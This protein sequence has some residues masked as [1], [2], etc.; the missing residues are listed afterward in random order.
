MIMSII[1]EQLYSLIALLSSIWAMSRLPSREGKSLKTNDLH[2]P[3]K[4]YRGVPFCSSGGG[5]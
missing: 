3:V 4:C 5:R 2:D 1:D